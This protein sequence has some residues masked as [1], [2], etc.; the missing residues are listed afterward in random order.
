MVNR[1]ID[2]AIESVVASKIG[3][4]HPA[5]EE[6]INRYKS[7]ATCLRCDGTADDAASFKQIMQE[8]MQE[9]HSIR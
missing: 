2:A 3:R 5:A 1:S 8:L 9:L 4:N 7:Q 6:I